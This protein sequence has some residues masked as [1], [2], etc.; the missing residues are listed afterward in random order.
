MERKRRKEEEKAEQ[1]GKKREASGA[2]LEDR[3]VKVEEEVRGEK[4]KA[5]DEG[6]QEQE[7]R[8]AKAWRLGR[9]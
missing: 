3:S 9:C 4:R 8:A 2:E 5:E 7:R 1:G 6:W